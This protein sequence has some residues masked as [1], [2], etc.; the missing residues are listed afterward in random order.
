MPK[1]QKP[2]H[3]N[4]ERKSKVTSVFL[5]EQAEDMAL[6]KLFYPEFTIAGI[7]RSTIE[8][9]KEANSMIMDID[10]KSKID[11]C[12]EDVNNYL[13]QIENSGHRS[14]VIP[15][16]S[17]LY[18]DLDVIPR[19]L[20]LSFCELLLCS[21]AQ[22]RKDFI[23]TCKEHGYE[24]TAV[25]GILP[26]LHYNDPDNEKLWEGVSQ[27]IEFDDQN[28][29]DELRILDTDFIDG[30]I[31]DIEEFLECVDPVTLQDKLISELTFSELQNQEV[32]TELDCDQYHDHDL[33]VKILLLKTFPNYIATRIKA[34]G[35]INATINQLIAF[36]KEDDEIDNPKLLIDFSGTL[37]RKG[38]NFYLPVRIVSEE[39]ASHF[40]QKSLVKKS[41][42]FFSY[43][44]RTVPESSLG[45][46]HEV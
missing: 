8:Q 40:L 12:I 35:D 33:V 34:G 32:S 39:D 24:W 2:S 20:A 7:L 11:T 18:K 38:R 30:N 45:D 17:T 28:K 9:I 1:P 31:V 36:A 37:D 41:K 29:Y 10:V 21:S 3:E 4:Q 6:L 42:E 15:R 23:L 19:T 26:E 46:Q 22:F 44:D 5:G 16:P 25:L 13:K 14:L 43:E 27:I